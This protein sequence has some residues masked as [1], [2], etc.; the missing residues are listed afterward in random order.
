MAIQATG[1][2]AATNH[3]TQTVA[4]LTTEIP[5]DAITYVNQSANDEDLIHSQR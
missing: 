4:N 1:E 3:S 5:R 2:D